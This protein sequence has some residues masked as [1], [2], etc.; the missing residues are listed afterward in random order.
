MLRGR[1]TRFHQK[2]VH[3]CGKFIDSARDVTEST[4]LATV[5]AQ[6]YNSWKL[7]DMISL[8][9]ILILAHDLR[10]AFLRLIEVQFAQQIIVL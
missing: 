9:K 5:R 10:G 6:H 3:C 1:R 8:R 2:R 4:E 7:L